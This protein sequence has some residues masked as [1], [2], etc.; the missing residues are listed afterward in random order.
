MVIH[1]ETTLEMPTPEQEAER[2]RLREE[3]Q[4]LEK[5]L[6]A[7]TAELETAQ[8]EWEKGV[9][10]ASRRPPATRSLPPI[11]RRLPRGPARPARRAQG[12]PRPRIR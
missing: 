4:G 7:P 11:P 10:A 1:H 9:R 3:I 8:A 2:K 12:R 6:N 5:V